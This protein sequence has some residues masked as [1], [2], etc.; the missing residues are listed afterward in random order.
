VLAGGDNSPTVFAVRAAEV[1]PATGQAAGPAAAGQELILV[2]ELPL[3]AGLPEGA[4]TP[5]PVRGLEAWNETW[6]VD[7]PQL[8]ALL[9]AFLAGLER[10]GLPQAVASQGTALPLWV[11]SLGLAAVACEMARRQLRRNRL[12]LADGVHSRL[13]AMLLPPSEE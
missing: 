8:E 2:A 5:E 6:L 7:L 3:P 13:A 11:L 4:L 10:L 9:G 1:L 12:A